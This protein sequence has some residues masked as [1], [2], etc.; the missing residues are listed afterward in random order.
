[1]KRLLL[2]CLALFAACS[3]PAPKAEETGRASAQPASRVPLAI[4]TA[5]GTQRF[6]VEVARTTREQE[7]GLMLRKSLDPQGGM[8]FPMNPPRTASFW[9]KDT[10][11]PLDMIF[12]RTDGTVAF[13]AA[14]TVPF[15]REPVSAGVPVAA[16][17]ELA[18]GRAAAI[19]AKA[20]DRVEWGRCAGGAEAPPTDLDFCPSPTR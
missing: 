19:G 6:I 15:S 18:G 7:R 8:L 13:I 20:G 17:L 11:I 4:H 3:Q 5:N 9:M 12:I 14:N 1:M 2:L 10:L 16:V